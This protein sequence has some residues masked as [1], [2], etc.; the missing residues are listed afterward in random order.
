MTND[1][2]FA[3]DCTTCVAANTTACGDCVVNH[4]L[5]ND[6]GPIDFLPTPRRAPVVS[7][8]ARVIDLF[9]NAGLLGDE[10]QFVAYSEFE[11]A[12]VPQLA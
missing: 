8:T 9:E 6:A 4:L 12:V 2:D 10:P 7:E 1:I 11:S 3:L 5:A